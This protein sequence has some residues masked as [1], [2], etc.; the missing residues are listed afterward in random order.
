[1]LYSCGLVFS[2]LAVRNK[3][4]MNILIP[5]DLGE[6]EGAKLYTLMANVLQQFAAKDK[7]VSTNGKAKKLEQD[8]E[9]VEC[10]EPEDEAGDSAAEEEEKDDEQKDEEKASELRFLLLF[11][12]CFGK[13]LEYDVGERVRQKAT[14]ALTEKEKLLERK[15]MLFSDQ[16]KAEEEEFLFYE[17]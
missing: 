5:Q 12:S 13:T 4:A 6:G 2:L 14:A 15:S 7:P 1:M 16:R 8:E 11:G 3:E 10:E 17:I 9:A